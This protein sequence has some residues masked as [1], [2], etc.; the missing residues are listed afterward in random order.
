MIILLVTLVTVSPEGSPQPGYI[1]KLTV[2]PF[3]IV[4]KTGE[5]VTMEAL[6]TNNVE[7]INIIISQTVYIIYFPQVSLGAQMSLDLVL[8]GIIP[9]KIPCLEVNDI[10]LGSW[11]VQHSIQDDL[12][13]SSLFTINY[14][15]I[16]II[17]SSNTD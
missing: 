7:V 13:T 9:I 15:V 2:S 4:I 12:L 8:E 6:F 1:N 14:R 17:I 3:P 16:H 5:I 11:W 10:H